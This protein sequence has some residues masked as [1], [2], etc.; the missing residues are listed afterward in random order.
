MQLLHSI[1]RSIFIPACLALAVA[2]PPAAAQCGPDG[3]D[4]GP[5][6]APTNAILPAFPSLTTDSLFIC[7]DNC[8][9]SLVKTYCAILGPPIPM[10]VNGTTLCGVYNIRIRLVDCATGVGFWTGGVRAFYSRNWQESSAAG[11]VDLNVWRF[12]VNGDFS[13]TPLVPNTPCERPG[14]TVQYNRIYFSGHVDYALECATGNWKTA[15]ALSHECD[16]IHHAPG[17][18]RPA[19]AI[20]LH[21]TRSFTMVGPGSTFVPAVTTVGQSNGPITNQAIR[22][23]RWVATAPTCTFEERAQGI[24]QAQNPFCF[25]VTAALTPQYVPT[26]VQAIGSCGSTINPSGMGPFL[27]KRLG[28]WTNPAQFPGVEQLLFDFGWL[29]TVD[30]CTGTTSQEWYEGS[31]TL[32]GFPALD[33]F[34]LPLDPQFEDLGSSNLSTTSAAV[35][36]GAPHFSNVLLNFNLP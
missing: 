30:G 33:F 21:P 23:N 11:T 26:L 14:C 25:C 34:G 35:Q 36:I 2:A 27:Q 6:C 22:W 10:T 18:A 1:S 28:G 12:V 4:G 16:G 15:F 32:K 29:L 13:P 8:Q 31:E 19:P 9:T 17:T 3:L 24:F 5:C 7:Y 20:G